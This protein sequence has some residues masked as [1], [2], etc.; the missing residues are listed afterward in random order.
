MFRLTGYDNQDGHGYLGDEGQLKRHPTLI[1]RDA[2]G[3]ILGNDQGVVGPRHLDGEICC[4]T[5][6]HPM[7]FMSQKPCKLSSSTD[8][9]SGR[10]EAASDVDEVTLGA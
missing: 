5:R 3:L 8:S 2:D 6:K 10:V 9:H 4:V 1:Q 7:S